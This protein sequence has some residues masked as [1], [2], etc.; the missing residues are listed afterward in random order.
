MNIEETNQILNELEHR[1]ECWNLVTK[2]T[3]GKLQR[4]VILNEEKNKINYICKF[5]SCHSVS[6]EILSAEIKPER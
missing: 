6:H 4:S 2:H 3:T 1:E 5:F